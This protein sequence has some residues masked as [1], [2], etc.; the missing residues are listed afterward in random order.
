MRFLFKSLFILISAALLANVAHSRNEPV[1][2]ANYRLAE[3]F[4]PTKLDRMVFSTSVSPGWLKTG[5]KFWY[6]YKTSDGTFYYLVDLERQT[7]NYLF[8]NHEMARQLTLIT[9]DPYDHQNLPAIDP[10]FV[11]DDR[12]F[13]FKV[14]S[15]KMVE[16]EEENDEKEEE[17]EI[18]ENDEMEEEEEEDNGEKN[19]ERS[20]ETRREPKVF[21]LEYNIETGELYEVEEEEKPEPKSWANV[22][23]DST[24]VVF[25]RDY[26]LFWMDRENYMK[27]I[28]DENDTTIV[29][30]RLTESGEQY[31][32]FGGGYTPEM[33]DD[34]E[35]IE[36]EM[37]KRR[38]ANIVWSPDSRRFAVI[39]NDTRDI[40][41]L[42]VINSMSDPRPELETYKYQMPGEEHPAESE[43]WVF[44][45]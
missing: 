45:M 37:K 32:A 1:T 35:K 10:E 25:A 44:D 36:E 11:R 3:R 33:N 12:F 28:E 26:N 15:T 30:H 6:S 29:E 19:N 27:A 16:V 42:W 20:R 9:K 23:P 43:L 31:Y 40:K 39:R 34:K 7:K 18:E 38:R 17:E 41:F 4:S 24:Y 2:E 14:R 5:D 13:R 8:D 22:S 21:H